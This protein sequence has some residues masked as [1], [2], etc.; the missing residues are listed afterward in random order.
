MYRLYEDVNSKQL[1]IYQD[2]FYSLENNPNLPKPNDKFSTN[3]NKYLKELHEAR[4]SKAYF[5]SLKYS[6]NT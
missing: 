5:S 6:M 1:E 3:M 4:K 2:N